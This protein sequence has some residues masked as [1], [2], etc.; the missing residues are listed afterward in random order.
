MYETGTYV[1]WAS[2]YFK[3]CLRLTG[4]PI[5]EIAGRQW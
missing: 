4:S 1:E 3:L 2:P 5:Q